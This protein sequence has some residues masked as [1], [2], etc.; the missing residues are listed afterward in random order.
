MFTVTGQIDWEVGHAHLSAESLL[1]QE[2]AEDMCKNVV[3]TRKLEAFL[4]YM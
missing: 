1:S 3:I 4:I 2:R